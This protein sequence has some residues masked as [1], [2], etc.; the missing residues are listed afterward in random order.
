M[1]RTSSTSFCKSQIASFLYKRLHNDCAFRQ[2]SNTILFCSAVEQKKLR[3]EIAGRRH[4]ME[5]ARCSSSLD[6]PVEA[7][8]WTSGS[9]EEQALQGEILAFVEFMAHW[10]IFWRLPKHDAKR[11]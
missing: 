6:Y 1:L 8:A 7:E 11:E 4:S 10:Q 9:V 5:Q 3:L 2:P